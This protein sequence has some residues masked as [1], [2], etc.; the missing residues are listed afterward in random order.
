M[1]KPPRSNGANDFSPSVAV[2]VNAEPLWKNLRIVGALGMSA[3]G[4]PHGGHVNPVSLGVQGFLHIEQLVQRH[5][6]GVDG[7]ATNDEVGLHVDHKED[8]RD[9]S[10]FQPRATGP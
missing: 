5:A 6:C 10:S 3:S 1:S 9:L 2:A 7:T 4:G 8:I